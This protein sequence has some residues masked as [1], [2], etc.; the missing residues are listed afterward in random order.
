MNPASAPATASSPPDRLMARWAAA[1]SGGLA[2]T[3]VLVHLLRPDLDPSWR[4]VSEYALGAYGWLM[5]LAFACWGL[6]PIAL[7]LAIRGAAAT[8]GAKVGVGLLIL[9]GVGPL[10]AAVFPMDP[11]LTPPAPMTRSG[12]VHAA[13]AVLG[14]LVP[15]G[16]LVLSNAL[17]RPQ[18]PWVGA[19]K[20][21]R[22]SAWVTF[23]LLV[24]ATA[25]MA[26]LMPESGQLGPD[27]KVGW[28]MRAFILACNGW[29]A[30][31]AWAALRSSAEP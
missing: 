8:R 2:V 19:R 24:A 20:T 14:D 1:C 22:A 3:L 4:P 7:A 15:I 16:A 6:G 29:V 31:G 26:A 10:L 28:L 30:V 23:G 27:V 25:A 13:S 11:L 9:G 12:T 17:T 5:T 21:V 18:G